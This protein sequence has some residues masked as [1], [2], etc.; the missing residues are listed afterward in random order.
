MQ[1]V[2]ALTL[3]IGGIVSFVTGHAVASIV[4]VLSGFAVRTFPADS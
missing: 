2:I 4:L 1:G 3:I